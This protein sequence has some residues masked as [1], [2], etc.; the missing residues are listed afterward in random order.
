MSY[1]FCEQVE[2]KKAQPKEVMLPQQLARGRGIARGKCYTH[3]SP[4]PVDI[5]M[6]HS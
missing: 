6:G 4:I 5:W 2:C 3:P 1:L